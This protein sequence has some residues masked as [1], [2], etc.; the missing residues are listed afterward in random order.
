MHAFIEVSV[1]DEGE[2]SRRGKLYVCLWKE[3]GEENI[4]RIIRRM[5]YNGA[6][7]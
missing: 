3:F 4:G 7:K 6:W 2:R 5:I 1:D